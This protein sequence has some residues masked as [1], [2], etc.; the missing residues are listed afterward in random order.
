MKSAARVAVL[1]A[2][3][4]VLLGASPPPAPLPWEF[5]RD[6]SSLARLPS[7]DQVVLRS[8]HCPSGCRFDR[9]SDGDP[10]FLRLDGDEAVILDEP[11][12]GAITR[13]WMTMGQ[14]LSEPLD[15]AIRLRVRID[16]EAQPR[17]DLTL[18]ELFSGDHPPFTPPL[19]LDRLLS[20][21]GNVSYVPIH[22]RRGC[23]IT[24]VGAERAR[25][26]YQITFHRLAKPGA[27][28]SFRGDEDL[29]A[30]REMLLAP[31]LD[32]WPTPP[33]R[34]RHVA[35]Q[36]APG[37][38]AVAWERAGAGELRSLR[39]RAAPEQWRR[40]WL[41]LEFDGAVTAR[42]PLA[43]FF[44]VGRGG[45]TPTRSLLLGAA[46]DAALYSYFPMPFFHGAKVTL[47]ARPQATA[48][49]P[50]EIDL[51]WRETAPSPD[52]GLF[53]ASR[54]VHDSIDPERDVPLLALSGRGKWVGVFLDLESIGAPTRD[55]LEG[56]E[57]VYVDANSSPLHH[58]T[59]VEDFF[60]GGFFFDR[61]PIVH[62]LH[63]A[64]YI[65]ATPSGARVDGMY[66]LLLADAVPF[67]WSLNAGL[68]LGP[69]PPTGHLRM[70]ARAVA[71][72]YH[73]SGR[74]WALADHVD[75]G[76]RASRDAH[77]YAA[78]A[79][80]QCASLTALYETQPPRERTAFGCAFARGGSRFLLRRRDA[81]GP[82]RL[83]RLLDVGTGAPA[84]DVWVDGRRVASFPFVAANPHRRWQELD[85]DLP[86]IP[87]G[88]LLRLEVFPRRHGGGEWR[89]TEYRYELWQ[90]R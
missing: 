78:P 87:G 35:L 59:G 49:V 70:A 54:L 12:A 22:Y 74:P 16:G 58:G 13:I 82:A 45:A 48:P 34:T 90:P 23:K 75:I 84:A 5:W 66:R 61:G 33:A 68:E 11:G 53:G 39:V 69:G 64:P 26:W 88:A 24:L 51:G 80:A 55:Y 9:T 72:H 52:S 21:G 8:S 76:S 1:C 73:R 2:A 43:D 86:P 27:V 20:S 42:M 18:R 56:D 29:E 67:Q 15:P 60:N 25:I 71:Y 44:A 79:G 19:V 32:P 28:R 17:V 3:V 30:L 7:G 50:I 83:R 77:A 62:A 85:L 57:H 10:R 89:H 14:G 36:L 47:G 37:S 65:L 81:G 63:G 6:L 38:R 40:V 31:G 46:E 41:E 4:G